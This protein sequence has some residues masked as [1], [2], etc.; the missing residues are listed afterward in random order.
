MSKITNVLLMSVIALGVAACSTPPAKVEK[1]ADCVFPGTDKA[2]PLWVCDA[3]VEGMSVGAVGSA[4]KSD[5][6]IAF[7][8]Q[9]AATEARVQLAQN[10]K[11]Q[12]QNMIKQYAETTGAGSKETVDRV[13]TSVTKQI[14]DQTLQGTK[15]FR[16]IVAPDGTMYVLVG[17]DEAAAQKLT[18][19]A[20]KTS[21]NND[22]AAWQQ[23]RAQKGQDELAAD[24]AKQKIGNSGT[25]Q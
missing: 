16:S 21:M 2:A 8:K 23:F 17:L 10:M 6:G 1:V 22:Q 4:A 14:T 7:M 9:M 20:V 12:V 13:N 3:P 24:I 15:I 11:V 5:A 18:E 25:G 19:T